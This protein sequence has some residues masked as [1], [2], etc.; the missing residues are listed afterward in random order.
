VQRGLVAS[1]VQTQIKGLKPID[2]TE[3]KIRDD[4]TTYAG[5]GTDNARRCANVGK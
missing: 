4:R 1:K 3:S 5:H 2:A